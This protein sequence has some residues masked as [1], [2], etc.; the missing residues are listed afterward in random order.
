MRD[1]VGETTLSRGH[2]FT[3][4]I[5]LGKPERTLETREAEPTDYQ[6]IRTTRHF[7]DKQREL[8]WIQWRVGQILVC[9]AR[10]NQDKRNPLSV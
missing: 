10:A 3:S 9:L 6:D 4:T 1:E 7:Q 2:Y 5:E 8:F